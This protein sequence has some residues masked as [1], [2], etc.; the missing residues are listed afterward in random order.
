MPLKLSA[1]CPGC[2]LILL[3]GHIFDV[4]DLEEKHGPILGLHRDATREEAR[5]GYVGVGS[6]FDPV[7]WREFYRC[8]K[9]GADPLIEVPD[10]ASE[11]DQH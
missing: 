3:S 1:D 11:I 4:V 6:F 10:M 8:P 7:K 5:A 2:G 9:C